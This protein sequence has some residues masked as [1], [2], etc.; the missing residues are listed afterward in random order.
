MAD[1]D[2]LAVFEVL[3]PTFVD[4]FNVSVTSFIIMPLF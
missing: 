2:V 4:N 1:A 3:L